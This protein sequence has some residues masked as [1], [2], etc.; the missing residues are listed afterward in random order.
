MDLTEGQ[1][2]KALPA[3]MLIYTSDFSGRFRINLVYFRVQ[4]HLDKFAVISY[5]LNEALSPS[6]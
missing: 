1:A 4:N 3:L 2:Y 6:K 5:Q